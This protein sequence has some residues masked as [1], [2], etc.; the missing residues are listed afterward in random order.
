M[1][2]RV[3]IPMPLAASP[4]VLIADEPTTGLDATIQSRVLDL[5]EEMKPELKTTTIV[6]T[7]DMGVARRLAD[8][9]AVMY[10]DGWWRWEGRKK[11]ST[12]PMSRSTLCLRPPWSHPHGRRHP[13]EAKAQC[14]RRGRSRSVS[15]RPWLPVRIPL[16]G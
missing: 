10:A 7:H 9:V 8:R 6:I 12:A 16:R 1:C 13:L 4:K 11:S 3:M 14:H 5:M 15:P 2:Q